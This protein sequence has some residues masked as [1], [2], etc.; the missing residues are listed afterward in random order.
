MIAEKLQRLSRPQL[1]LVVL[2]QRHQHPH[3]SDPPGDE[4][5]VQ[6]DGPRVVLERLLKFPAPPAVLG[7]AHPVLAVMQLVERDLR[8]RELLLPLRNLLLAV[9]L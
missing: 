4:R 8:R 6:L 9:L 7:L 1:G 2:L 3:L 5:A